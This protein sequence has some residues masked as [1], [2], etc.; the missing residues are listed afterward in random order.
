M[1]GVNQFIINFDYPR[2]IHVKL[3]SYI[4]KKP[5]MLIHLYHSYCSIPRTTHACPYMHVTLMIF[6][7]TT[8]CMLSDVSELLFIPAVVCML[9]CLYNRHLRLYNFLYIVRNRK[10][11]I[12]Y[13][14]FLTTQYEISVFL[15]HISKANL[16]N[17]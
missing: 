2:S 11:V 4:K 5:F 16:C 15:Y 3:L 10:F 7:I 1:T 6:F 17:V 13:F 14:Y 9:N 8:Y 12:C